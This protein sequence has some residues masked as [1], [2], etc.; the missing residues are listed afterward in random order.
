LVKDDRVDPA[1]PYLGMLVAI[2][3]VSFASIF[4]RWSESPPL[5]IAA[6]RMVLVSVILLPFALRY[7]GKEMRL[8]GRRDLYIMIIIGGLLG[9]HF[10]AYISS[11]KMTSVA[12]AVLLASWHPVLVGIL[13]MLWLKESSRSAGFGIIAGVLGLV[14][15]TAGDLGGSELDGDLVALFSG[16][17]FAFYLLLGRVLRQR[18][19]LITYV[20]L[21]FSSCAT[22]LLMAALLSGAPMWPVPVNELLIFLALAVI[23]TIF[24]HLL[25]NFSL[26][27]LGAAI[28]SVSYLGEPVG[29][30]LLAAL[31]LSET[32]SAYALVGGGMIMVGI[33]LTARMERMASV[34]RNGMRPGR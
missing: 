33:L 22:F 24:G 34:R 31:L 25:F 5:V 27:Y 23:S 26:R 8:M 3:G 19:S 28:V 20:F 14:I 7:S 15:I 30:T 12:S 10:F 6:W 1:I 13:A 18:T 16:V 2:V 9:A 11:V 4:I 32:P 17:L 29:A 21:V